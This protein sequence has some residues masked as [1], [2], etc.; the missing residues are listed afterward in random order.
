MG[1]G[2]LCAEVLAGWKL[3][4]IIERKFDWVN[5]LAILGLVIAVLVLAAAAWGFVAPIRDA[6][7]VLR[8]N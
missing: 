7:T 1:A 4:Q 2:F 5:G 6:W 3:I 8:Q